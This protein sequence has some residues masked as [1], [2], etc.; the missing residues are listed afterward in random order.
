MKFRFWCTTHHK[1]LQKVGGASFLHDKDGFWNI[2]ISDQWQCPDS[3]G[4]DNTSH[5]QYVINLPVYI[6]VMTC[7][8]DVVGDYFIPQAFFDLEGAKAY[9]KKEIGALGLEEGD[10][11]P[12]PIYTL[13]SSDGTKRYQVWEESV[14]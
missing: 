10:S 14:Q 7:D 2:D 11:C 13:W 12:G 4:V 1:A 5:C 6:V 9:C 3:D 8:E